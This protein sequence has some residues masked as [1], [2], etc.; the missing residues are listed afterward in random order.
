MPL[1]MAVLSAGELGELVEASRRDPEQALARQDALLS[2]A[3]ACLEELAAPGGGADRAA[4]CSVLLQ[5]LRAL[6]N[7]CAAGPAACAALLAGGA[8]AAVARLLAL[9]ESGA[10]QLDWQLPLVGAQLLANAA[11]AGAGCAGAVWAGA[12]PAQLNALAHISSGACPTEL[13]AAAREAGCSS[14]GCRPL[15]AG[16][17]G[18]APAVQGGLLSPGA[19]AAVAAA[20]A[21]GPTQSALALC[22][23]SCCRQV[24]GAAA[25][26]C[27]PAGAPVMA[28][29]LC[30]QHQL[31]EHGQGGDALGLL[32]C[33]LCFQRDLLGQLAASLAADAPAPS[34]QDPPAAAGGSAAEHEAEA[35]AAAAAAA[36]MARRPSLAHV[37][38]LQELAHEAQAGGHL[39]FGGEG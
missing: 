4:A 29:A 22:L 39:A 1:I 24:P 14:C 37:A 16:G 33:H 28:A 15:R 18:R 31:H 3:R 12:F 5:A 19:A 20:A 11:T 6:R 10:V 32:L 25:A 36:A 27:G 2:T 13:G 34:S 17:P 8:A 21:A 35:T 7:L 26:L 30:R 23:L 9:V 38:L